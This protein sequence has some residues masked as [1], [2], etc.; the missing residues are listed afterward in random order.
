MDTSRPLYPLGVDVRL[1]FEVVSGHPHHAQLPMP[2]LDSSRIGGCVKP[3]WLFQQ[4]CG[5]RRGWSWTRSVAPRGWP[6]AL[7]G[8]GKASRVSHSDQR[9]L[10]GSASLNAINSAIRGCC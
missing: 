4:A 10:N 3:W 9:G 1:V 7:P 5:A 6:H 8:G 2:L